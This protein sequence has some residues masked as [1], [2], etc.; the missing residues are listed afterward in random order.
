MGEILGQ[1]RAE[2]KSST[3][4]LSGLTMLLE[5]SDGRISSTSVL[6]MTYFAVS[7]S[8]TRPSQ[9]NVNAAVAS[10]RATLGKPVGRSISG[11]RGVKLSLYLS[12]WLRFV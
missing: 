6:L 8:S 2:T 1:R 12:Q 9:K 4:R 11:A 7:S 5:F 10:S 3:H